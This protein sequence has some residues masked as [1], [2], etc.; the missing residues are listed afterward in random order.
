MQKF[1]LVGLLLGAFALSGCDTAV[2]RTAG[3]A[4]AGAAIADLTGGS[5]RTGALIGALGGAATCG[6]QGMPR[7]Y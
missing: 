5:A 7:C 2:G 3:G 6:L 4:V 1:A